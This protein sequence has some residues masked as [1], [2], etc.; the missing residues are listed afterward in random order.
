MTAFDLHDP[1]LERCLNW[2]EH[3]GERLFAPVYARFAA[4]AM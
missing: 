3:G 4:S 1:S 2:F